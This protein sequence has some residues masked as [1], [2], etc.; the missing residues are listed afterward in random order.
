MCTLLPLFIIASE[1]L[2]A[3]GRGAEQSSATDI[4]VMPPLHPHPLSS[5]SP[6]E[7]ASGHQHI[8]I[9]N[10]KVSNHNLNSMLGLFPATLLTLQFACHALISPF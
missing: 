4:E 9:T 1:M 6:P 3:A 2:G 10:L 5:G 8:S 7:M